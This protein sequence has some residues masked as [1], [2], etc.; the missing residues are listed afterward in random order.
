VNIA[1]ILTIEP[2]QR[3]LSEENFKLSQHL[4]SLG[5]EEQPSPGFNVGGNYESHYLDLASA[6]YIALKTDKNQH[7]EGEP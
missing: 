6:N 7:K 5:E 2:R 1:F 4:Q 3:V